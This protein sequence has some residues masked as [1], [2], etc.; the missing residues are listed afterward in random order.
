[1]HLSYR[2]TKTESQQGEKGY[3]WLFFSAG[4]PWLVA[5]LVTLLLLALSVAFFVWYLH[6]SSDLSSD[7]IAGYAYAIS[8]TICLVL[9]A[10]LYSVRRRSRRRAVGQLNAALNWHVFLGILGIALLFMHSFGNFNPRTGTYALYG[11]IALVISGFVGRT[12]DRI[13]PRL[14]A[15]EVRKALTE[16]GDDRIEHI[17]QKLQSIVVHNNERVQAFSAGS[18]AAAKSLVPVPF[19][20]TKQSLNTPWDLAYISLEATPQEL[21]AEAPQYRFIPDKKSNLARPGALMPGAQEH[22]SEL[23]RVQQAMRREQFYRY[24]IRYWRL[25]HVALALLTVGLTIWHIVY[26]AQLLIPTFLH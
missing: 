21:S 2:E 8:G 1:M 17:S 16:Q 20:P 24:I 19:E 12:L 9:A 22:I 23:E 14:I 10:T 18:P 11:M 13:M 4:R 26:A 6:H 3:S 7:S 15:G 25:F 5:L